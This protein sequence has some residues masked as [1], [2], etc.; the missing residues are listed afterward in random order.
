MSKRLRKTLAPGWFEIIGGPRDGQE[1][2]A[3]N[4]P[5][6]GKPVYLGLNDPTTQYEFSADCSAV[7]WTERVHVRQQKLLPDK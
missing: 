1:Y 4:E 5:R 2:F 7:V 3:P 6:R